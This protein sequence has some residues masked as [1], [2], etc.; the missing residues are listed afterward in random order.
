MRAIISATIVSFFCL[1]ISFPSFGQE[2][3]DLEAELHSVT[4]INETV[5]KLTPHDMG[6]AKATNI[7][8][9][10]VAQV[11]GFRN[12]TH[13]YKLAEGRYSLLIGVGKKSYNVGVFQHSCNLD[14]AY[15]GL[16]LQN[17]TIR[18]KRREEI[19]PRDPNRYT[20]VGNPNFTATSTPVETVSNQISGDVLNGKAI[21]LPKPPYP[22]AAR[23]ERASGAV[24]VQVLIDEEGNVVSASAV[25]GH[26]LLRAAAVAAARGAKFSPIKLEGQPVKVS[27]VI[28]YNFVP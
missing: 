11:D 22:A 21:I 17:A 10:K 16:E 6:F 24:S 8:T 5:S 4:K 20:V 9:K 28:T 26:P 19:P 7:R 3:C 27:G 14:K 18:I 13:F 15:L 23:A 12:K 25:S 1:G 2:R